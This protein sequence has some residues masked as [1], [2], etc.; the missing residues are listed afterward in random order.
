[1]RNQSARTQTLFEQTQAASQRVIG[2]DLSSSKPMS[3]ILLDGS[4]TSTELVHNLKL[5][6]HSVSLKKLRELINQITASVKARPDLRKYT[7]TQEFTDYVNYVQEQLDRSTTM[8]EMKLEH[9]GL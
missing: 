8:E 9:G 2:R 5:Y 4:S 3:E 6:S 1:M 7:E